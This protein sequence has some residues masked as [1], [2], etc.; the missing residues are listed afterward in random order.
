MEVFL[1]NNILN[2]NWK[3]NL[4]IATAICSDFV[5]KKRTKTLENVEISVCFL[6]I[7]EKL[8]FTC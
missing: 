7:S 4:C 8:D 6:K 1:E 5:K 3:Q 2:L